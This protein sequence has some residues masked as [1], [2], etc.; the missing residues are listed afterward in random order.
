MTIQPQ[1]VALGYAHEGGIEHENAKLIFSPFKQENNTV[2]TQNTSPQSIQ[3]DITTVAHS[4]EHLFLTYTQYG[5]VRQS[6]KEKKIHRSFE[7]FSHQ[8]NDH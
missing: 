4:Y 1:E 2:A 3:S 7:L 8:L 6:G 5:T